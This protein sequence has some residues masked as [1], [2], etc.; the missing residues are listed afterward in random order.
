[1]SK[2]SKKTKTPATKP[3]PRFGAL[4]ILQTYAVARTAAD[5]FA[6]NYLV[7][8]ADEEVFEELNAIWLLLFGAISRRKRLQ[9]RVL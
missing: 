7:I 1:M 3:A 9:G 2:V 6:A 4:E 5:K 8:E